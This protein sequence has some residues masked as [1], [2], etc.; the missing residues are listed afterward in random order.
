MRRPRK[1]FPSARAYLRIHVKDSESRR[2]VLRDIHDLVALAFL[3][4]RPAGM[5]INHIDGNKTNNVPSNLEY[6][7]QK[8]NIAHSYRTGTW[9]SAKRCANKYAGKRHYQPSV[10]ETV[11]PKR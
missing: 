9:W 3:G 5:V 10:N 2:K 11:E 4:P 6:V 7:T 8:E 1:G